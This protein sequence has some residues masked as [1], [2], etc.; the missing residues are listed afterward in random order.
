MAD[1]RITQILI[2]GDADSPFSV[3]IEPEAMEYRFPPQQHV[4]LTFRGP[5]LKQQLEVR[6]GKNSLTIW[7]PGD[8]EVWATLADRSHE[9]IGGFKD[10]PFPWLDSGSSA[11]GPAPW[12]WP[13]TR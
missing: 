2:S 6:Y 1:A 10:N 11:S 5:D 13:E 9:Q 3:V 8:T 4:L 7:R 12:T